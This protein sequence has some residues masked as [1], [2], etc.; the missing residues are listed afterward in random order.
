MFDPMIFDQMNVYDIEFVHPSGNPKINSKNRDVMNI[1]LSNL[2]YV[3]TVNVGQ[4]GLFKRHQKKAKEILGFIKREY[5][6]VA[7]NKKK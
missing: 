6:N 2:H 5:P 7:V 3:K 4:L 1:F